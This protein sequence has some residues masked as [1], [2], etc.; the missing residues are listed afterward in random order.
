M[1]SRADSYITFKLC[2]EALTL[3]PILKKK[4]KTISKLVEILKFKFLGKYAEIP[5]SIEIF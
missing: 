4:P 1:S 2:L 3:K 5:A